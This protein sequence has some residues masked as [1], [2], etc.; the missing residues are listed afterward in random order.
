[1]RAEKA[2]AAFPAAELLRHIKA[3]RRLPR[4][5]KLPPL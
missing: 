1:L 5:P 4:V 2:V 3:E